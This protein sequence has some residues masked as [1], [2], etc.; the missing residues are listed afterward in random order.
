MMPP[1][2]EWLRQALSLDEKN[3]AS[4]AGTFIER[5]HMESQPGVEQL[6]RS[7]YIYLT[8]A[9]PGVPPAVAGRSW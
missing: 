1:A 2:E 7:A 8:A 4:F 6:R 3:R 5:A 9:A